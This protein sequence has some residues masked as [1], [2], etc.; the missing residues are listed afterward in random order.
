MTQDNQESLFHK[1]RQ[2]LLKAEGTPFEEEAAAFM[3]KAQELMTRY[4]IDEE[5]LWSSDPSRRTKI[6]EAVVIIEDRSSGAYN[7]RMLLFTIACNN[8][9]RLWLTKGTGKNHIAGFPND[10]LFVEMLYV[11]IGVQLNFAMANAMAR[12][13]VTG[14]SRSFRRDF[15]AG[16]AERVIDRLEEAK[17]NADRALQ[18][19]GTS[20]ELVLRDRRHKVD[21]WVSDHVPGLRPSNL[22]DRS[23]YNSARA[24]GSIAA[25]TAD[26]SGGR[27]GSLSKAKR[28]LNA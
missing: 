6:E 13:D 7:K 18:G 21:E 11:S 3:A 26:I 25:E 16:F 4:A 9:C 14:N 5:T 8:S 2:L 28:E 1:V 17:L 22:S 20:T 19:D 23:Q 12:M 10:V 24:A 27:G 15:I